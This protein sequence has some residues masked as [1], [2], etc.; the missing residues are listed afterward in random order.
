MPRASR[1]D[2]ARM[3][4]TA[5]NC[6]IQDGASRSGAA[7][8]YYTLFALAHVLIVMIAISGAVFGQDAVRGC[9][10]ERPRSRG[11]ALR[12]DGCVRRIAVG[13]EQYPARRVDIDES[14]RCQ[15]AC[16][17]TTHII[18][19]CRISRIP[20]A[21]LTR[22]Q[23][24]REC[25]EFVG[26]YAHAWMACSLGHRH[27]SPLARGHRRTL[28]D[29][30]AVDRI[31]PWTQRTRVTVRCGWH[32]RRHPGVGRLFRANRAARRGVHATV[33]ARSRTLQVLAA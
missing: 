16:D 19:R 26:R 4:G 3:F 11:T 22:C 27:S 2:D 1:V 24:R 31:V 21:G 28:C 33:D 29:R 5:I 10:R 13:I 32:G 25:I 15:R 9:H 12:G 23:R 18:R 6:W 14:S 17:T 30:S 8:S 20:A 7:I